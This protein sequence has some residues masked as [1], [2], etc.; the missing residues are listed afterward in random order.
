MSN[1]IFATKPDWFWLVY[2]V[3]F[4]MLVINACRVSKRELYRL[5]L[6]INAGS[7]INQFPVIRSIIHLL[8][9]V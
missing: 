3:D 8:L 6:F 5:F 7:E 4:E 1:V 2:I 9:S